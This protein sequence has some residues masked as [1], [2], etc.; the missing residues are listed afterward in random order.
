MKFSSRRKASTFRLSTAKVIPP[1]KLKGA[2]INSAA[3]YMLTGTRWKRGI[4]EYNGTID[5]KIEEWSNPLKGCISIANQFDVEVR[6]RT[7]TVGGRI[8]GRYVDYLKRIGWDDGGE[9]ILGKDLVGVKR[10]EN[11]SEV[12]T[13]MVGVGKSSTPGEYVTFESINGGKNYIEDKGALQRWS[14]DGKHLFGLW[15]VEP[16]EGEETVTPEMVKFR[17]ELAFRDNIDSKVE[18]EVDSVALEQFG[19]DHERI[20]LGNTRRIKDEGFNPPLYLE[21]RVK[22][23][24]RRNLMTEVKA[25][26]GNYKEIQ[27]NV[28]TQLKDLQMKLFSGNYDTVKRVFSPTPPEDKTVLW[29]DVSGQFA[30]VKLYDPSIPDWVAVGPEVAGDLGAYTKLEIDNKYQQTK[31]IVQASKVQ[32]QRSLMLRALRLE[33]C[34]SLRRAVVSST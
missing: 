3:D 12:Y 8:V 30:I 19:M 4:S 6:F 16:D 17:T 9:T 34:L 24:E 32:T 10:K 21:A 22:E 20:R 18:Y 5:F 11:S 33:L 31:D 15:L 29:V 25:V 1:G 7:E 28:F 26:Y 27:P 2:T 23:I 14:D 13:A